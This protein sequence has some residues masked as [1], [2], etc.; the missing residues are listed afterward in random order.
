LKLPAGA[1]A[2]LLGILLV[3]GDFVPGFSAIDRQTQILGYSVV[4]GFAQQL[5]TQWL[6]QRGKNLVANVPTKAGLDD[7]RPTDRSDP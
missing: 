7:N 6:D 3:A 4:F 1:T 5:F 2:A